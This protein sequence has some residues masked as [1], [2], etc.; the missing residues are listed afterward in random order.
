MNIKSLRKNYEQLSKRERMILYDSADNRDDNGEMDAIMLAT[1]NENW[2]K[3]DFALE[4]EQILKVRLVMLAQSLKHSR[5]ALFWFALAESEILT[6]RKKIKD[7]FFSDSA[8]LEAYF[9]CV[10]IDSALAIY[11]EIGL[12]L[13]AWKAKEKEI[14]DFD[15]VDEETDKIMRRIAFTEKEAEAFINEIGKEKGFK[16]VI[17]GFTVEKETQSLREILKNQGFADYFKD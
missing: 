11:K 13:D 3:P 2:I 1:P 4:A 17:L 8:K 12:D 9:Y 10:N 14:F 16:N 15:F 5:K 7:Q 6:N